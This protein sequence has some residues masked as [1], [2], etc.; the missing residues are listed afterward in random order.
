M[1]GFPPDPDENCPDANMSQ[2]QGKRDKPEFCIEDCRRIY[3]VV[4]RRAAQDAS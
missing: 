4:G 2:R 3:A 1:F